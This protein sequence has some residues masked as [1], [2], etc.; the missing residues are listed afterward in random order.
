[1]AAKTQLSS[2]EKERRELTLNQIEKLLRKG[3][4][5]R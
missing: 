1:M 4:V 5:S 3:G 2:E